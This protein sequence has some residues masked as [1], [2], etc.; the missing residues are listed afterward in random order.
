[1]DLAEDSLQPARG[2]QIAIKLLL[3]LLVGGLGVGA[4]LWVRQLSGQPEAPKRQV[5]K[6]SLLPD[7]PPPPPPPPPKE[8]KPPP[9]APNKP[10]PESAPKPAEAAQP[11]NEPIKM[12]GAAG[13]GPS[14][15]AAGPV[16]NEYIGGTPATGAA[17]SGSGS[18]RALERFFA[19]TARQLLRDALE[20]HLKSERS[21]AL[22]EFRV[23]VERDGSI[24]RHALQS[25]GDVRLDA[26]LNA[27]LDEAARSLKLPPPPAA[28]AQPMKFRLQLRPL[29]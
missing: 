29:G 3:T 17:Q 12:E 25:T 27:A 20:K 5:A 2:R 24:A 6:I 1:M 13:D 26:E 23:W 9:D 4:A 7:Q 21:E 15:F 16:R 8:I 10:M 28:A 11:R 19:S 22:A 14:A 18:D